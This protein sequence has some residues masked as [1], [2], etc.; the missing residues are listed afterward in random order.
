MQSSAPRIAFAIETTLGNAVFLDNLKRALGRRT[1]I[2]PVWLPIAE[3]ADDVWE[4]LPLVRSKLSVRG[5]LRARSALNQAFALEPVRAAVVHTQRLAHLSHD[6]MRRVPSVISTDATPSG[7]EEY[8]RYY[9]LRTQHAGWMGR[10]KHALHRR[11]YTLAKGMLSFSRFTKRSLVEEYGVPD[12]RVHVVWPSV[13]TTLWRPAPEKKPRDGVVRLLFVGSDL[14][15]KGGQLLMR[16]AWETRRRNWRLDVVTSTPFKPPPGV[17]IHVGLSPNSPELIG[18]AQAADLFVLPTLADMSSWAI[19]EAKAAGLAVV[20][21]PAGGVGELVR[22]GVDGRIV[23]AGDY[24][25]LAHTLDALV[26]RPETLAA[27]GSE[28][29]RMAEEHLDMD[30][31]CSRMLAFIR[32]VTGI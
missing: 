20:T 18:L 25:A 30:T 23:P 11:T 24:T 2:T 17:R 28:S 7:L 19:A 16:W 22:D 1:D 13:D 15:R 14:G 26:R 3:H 4:Q 9:G 10:A 21:T 31:T 12:T 8:L 27:M 5:G 6:F 32:Q 29:R